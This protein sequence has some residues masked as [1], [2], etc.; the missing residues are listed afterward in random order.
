MTGPNPQKSG[1]PMSSETVV[2]AIDAKYTK[3]LLSKVQLAMD[4][5]PGGG[6]FNNREYKCPL[7]KQTRGTLAIGKYL[8]AVPLFVK[9]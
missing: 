2:G 3:D 9:L 4:N 8:E 7:S 5:L 6:N 1:L